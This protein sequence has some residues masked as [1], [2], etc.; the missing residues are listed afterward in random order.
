M[1]SVIEFIV[2][3]KKKCFT[4]SDSFSVK[5]SFLV[6]YFNH[7]ILFTEQNWINYDDRPYELETIEKI[8]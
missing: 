2:I 8:A 6:P 7:T 4:F 1:N 5:I 3:V